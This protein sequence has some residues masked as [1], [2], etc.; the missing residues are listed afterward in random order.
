MYML[1]TVVLGA[2]DVFMLRELVFFLWVGLFCVKD[3]VERNYGGG[4][5]IRHVDETRRL[6]VVRVVCWAKRA[7]KH[8][9]THR[10]RAGIK[11]GP[12]GLLGRLLCA[13]FLPTPHLR[14]HVFCDCRG[15]VST[16]YCRHECMVDRLL[17]VSPS[18]REKNTPEALS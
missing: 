17:S 18:R 7:V 15:K 16:G 8:K 4:G 14:T 12:P 6:T 5:F 9:K 3:D 1:R 13:C 11:A 2:R 10:H